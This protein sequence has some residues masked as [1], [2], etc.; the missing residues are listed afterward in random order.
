MEPQ[1]R[2]TLK[3]V[4]VEKV[5]YL[6]QEEEGEKPYLIAKIDG[7]LRI[8][9]LNVDG[10]RLSL[11]DSSDI[12]EPSDVISEKMLNL[13]QGYMEAHAS[14]E[15]LS[16]NSDLD[17]DEMSGP[18]YGPEDIYVENKPFSLQQICDLINSGDIDLTPDF[19]R[20]FVWDK[21]QQSRLIESVLLGLPI[22]SIYLSQFSD[23]L[24]TIVD[25][26]QRI[27]TIKNFMDDKLTLCN[28]EY[29][30]DCNG[31]KFSQLREV[32][33]MLRIRRFGQ[34]QIMC[35]VIDWRSPSRLKYDIFKR[36]NT[37]GKPLNK[38]E[39]RNCLSRNA[40][41]KALMSMVTTEEFKLATGGSIK[42]T[43]MD[44]QEAALRFL[45]F[46]ELYRKNNSIDGYNGSIDGYNG[47]MDASLND[48]VD[49]LNKRNDFEEEIKIY[50]EVMKSAYYLFRD[51]AF[52]KIFP[53]SNK[54]RRSLINKILMLCISVLLAQYSFEN[55]KSK[56]KGGEL[57]EPMALLLEKDNR[58]YESITIGTNGKSNIQYVLKT[59][60][61]NI[62]N[63]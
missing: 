51:F 58:F 38:Q 36:L 43:R 23:G 1:V 28:L 29:L 46:N 12:D 21:T 20:N 17:E 27:H 56:Y 33:S 61:E 31:K 45:Y 5:F 63:K 2:F 54:N 9:P 18:G 53:N 41:R 47:D 10:D 60:S 44:A 42:T 48:Y 62:F 50:S 22:P 14:G 52:R 13:S 49:I 25:G 3:D 57:I 34:T 19:Q 35:F 55:I 11:E 7:K 32:L 26:L 59:L 15:D 37:G 6:V 8:L 16:L 30:K 39:I 4:G 40:V 24:L